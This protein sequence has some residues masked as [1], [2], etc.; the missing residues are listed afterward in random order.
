MKI[1]LLATQILENIVKTS[2]FTLFYVDYE[3]IWQDFIKFKNSSSN[4]EYQ[5]LTT[6]QFQDIFIDY[7][8]ESLKPFLVKKP[9][10]R[11][12]LMKIEKV[13]I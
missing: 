8:A 4:T 11:S 1:S 7:F 10:V 12:N 9:K 13:E 6:H 5:N 2:G 3:T